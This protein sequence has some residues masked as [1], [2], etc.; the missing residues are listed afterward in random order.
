[1]LASLAVAATGT[2]RVALGTLAGTVIDPRGNPVSGASVT[3][4]TSDG[5]HPHATRTNAR[6]YFQ[7]TDYAVGQYDLRAY[8][9][10]ENSDW[11][12]RIVVRSHKTTKIV[13]RLA[14]H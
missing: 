6:G 5:Q 14:R 10:G 1:M 8:F 13:L 9:H 2:A 4:Q 7:F 12:K 11:A 3:M